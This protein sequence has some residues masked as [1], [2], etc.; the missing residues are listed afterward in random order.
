VCAKTL[1]A[2]LAAIVALSLMVTLGCAK[3]SERTPKVKTGPGHASDVASQ[4]SSDKAGPPARPQ[5]ERPQQASDPEE[6]AK[7]I[8][9]PYYPEAR[10][11]P[12]PR[13]AEDVAQRIQV[14]RLMTT[15]PPEKVLEFYKKALGD[16]AKLTQESVDGEVIPILVMRSSQDVEL[17]VAVSRAPN[18]IRTQVTLIRK[19]LTTPGEQNQKTAKP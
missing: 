11:R 8:G 17:R 9:L 3:S 6:A 13:L 18:Q 19:L 12:G 2:S 4:P 7:Q 5:A 10:L 14:V 15:D 1:R 16:K